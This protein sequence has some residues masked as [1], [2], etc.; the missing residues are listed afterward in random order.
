MVCNVMHQPIWSSLFDRIGD[1]GIRFASD[2]LDRTSV[3][4]EIHQEGRHGGLD[5]MLSRPSPCVP[6]SESDHNDPFRFMLVPQSHFAIKQ[7]Y[8]EKHKVYT[9]RGTT[10]VTNAPWAINH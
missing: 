3:L 7:A 6:W 9:Y 10:A 8:A 1:R 5:S 4:V 2:G